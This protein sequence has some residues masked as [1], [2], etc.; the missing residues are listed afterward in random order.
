M[1]PA[2]L[3][4][5]RKSL[6]T[7]YRRNHPSGMACLYGGVPSPI[8]PDGSLYSLPITGGDGEVDVTYGDLYHG[9][10]FLPIVGEV[11]GDLTHHRATPLSANHYAFVSPS[12]A[13]RSSGMSAGPVAGWSARR[14]PRSWGICGNRVSRLETCSCSSGFSREWSSTGEDGVSYWE[15]GPST[16]CSD[17]YRW[18]LSNNTET[19]CST[20]LG[21]WPVTA[22]I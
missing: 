10:G 4:L 19:P 6:D 20:G 2:R 13:P 8:F 14:T 12:T 1:K 3:V 5:S 16:S 15:H 7:T 18:V 17:G 11:V 9:D 22:W 21:S